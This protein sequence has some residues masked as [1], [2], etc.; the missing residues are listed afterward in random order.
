M[1]TETASSRF[2]LATF[3]VVIGVALRVIPHPMNF[4]PVAAISLF[5]GATFDRRRDAFLIPLVTMLIGDVL[6]QLMTGQGLHSLMPVLYATFVLITFVGV[7]LREQRTR[8]FVV[9]GG[10]V[11]SSTLFFLISNFAMWTISV[12]F[13]RTL[14]GLGACYIAGIPFFGR[15]LASDLFFTALLFGAFVWAERRYPRFALAGAQ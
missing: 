5:A 4:A 9:A 14:Q 7:L 13:P 8:P 12:E 10:A 11:A 15:T 3:L 2:A 1:R 6:R